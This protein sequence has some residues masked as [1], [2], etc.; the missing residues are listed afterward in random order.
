VEEFYVHLQYMQNGITFCC[1]PNF[2]SNEEWYD[3][4]MVCFNSGPHKASCGK[5]SIGMWSDNYF[6]NKVMCFFVIPN[7]DTTYAIIHSSDVNDHD[8]NSILFE[9]WELENTSSTQRNGKWSITANLHVVDVDTF[10]NPI[11]VVEDYTI[12]DLQ[13]N[14]EHQMITVV[15]PF[16]KAWPN[17]FMSF[18]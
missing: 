13:G 18:H 8:N 1:H 2:K 16:A 12:K 7:D 10:G 17:K 4:V 3:W 6:Q 15:L 9:R 14:A 5:K 11:L